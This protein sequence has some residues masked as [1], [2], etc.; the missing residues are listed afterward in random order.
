[1]KGFTLRHRVHTL[2]RYEVHERMESAIL[3]EKAPKAWKR[4]CK[5]PLIEDAN[6]AW[7]DL[8]PGIL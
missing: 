1:M 4:I 3:R 7:R 5:L 8:H 6:P 2:V